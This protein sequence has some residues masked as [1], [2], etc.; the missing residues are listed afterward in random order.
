MNG[1]V[2]FLL[3]DDIDVA[4][5]AKELGSLGFFHQRGLRRIR[6]DVSSLKA[7]EMQSVRK[8]GNY[9]RSSLPLGMK[10]PFCAMIS[11]RKWVRQ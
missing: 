1:R 10:T 2:V 9:A 4:I 5:H 8:W 7:K 11:R 6:V 3:R